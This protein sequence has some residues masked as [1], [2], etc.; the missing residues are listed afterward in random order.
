MSTQAIITE[1][2][3]PTNDLLGMA[4]VETSTDLLKELRFEIGEVCHYKKLN[5]L[6]LARLH[7]NDFCY[8]DDDQDDKI[9]E[10]L[11]RTSITKIN[12]L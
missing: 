4:L 1:S 7:C 9:R 6:R 12:E 11:I 8:M 3:L 2:N 5:L 10:Y